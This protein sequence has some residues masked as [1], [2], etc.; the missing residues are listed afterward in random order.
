MK[1]IEKDLIGNDPLKGSQTDMD[2]R[3]GNEVQIASFETIAPQ[4]DNPVRR[5]FEIGQPGQDELKDDEITRNETGN[6]APGNT[7]PSRRKF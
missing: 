6:R 5:E 1:D 3:K 4:K 7:N 2:T